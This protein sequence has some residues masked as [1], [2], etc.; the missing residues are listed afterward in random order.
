MR[1][2]KINQ[3]EQVKQEAQRIEIAAME[4]LLV[5]ENHLDSQAIRIK[6]KKF[7]IEIWEYLSSLDK[8]EPLE[9]VS[10]IYNF[11]IGKFLAI[12]AIIWKNF[13]KGKRAFENILKFLG[14]EIFSLAFL[15]WRENERKKILLF[16]KNFSCKKIFLPFKFAHIDKKLFRKERIEI[17]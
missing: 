15:Y 1:K 10:S 11:W 7:W 17:S 13:G 8:W 2:Q 5:L 4:F 14:A 9:T 3:K 6:K 16:W 12:W